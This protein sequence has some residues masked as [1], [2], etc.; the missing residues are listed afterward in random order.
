MGR[1]AKY[2]LAIDQGTT[3]TRSYLFDTQGRVAGSAY[4]EFTQYFPRPGWVEHDA[5]EIWKSAAATTRKALKA[6]GAKP[7]DIAAIGITNQRETTLL[8]DRKSGKPV[9]RAIVWQCRRT[10]ARC[11]QLKKQGKEKLFRARTGLVLDAYFSGTKLEWLLK[12]VKGARQKARQGRLAF[13]T[14]DSWLLWK[15]SGG[16]VHATDYSNA[17]RTLLFNI[18]TKKWDRELCK[19]L[20]VPASLLPEVRASAADFGVTG[21]KSFLGAGI[22]IAG[23]AGDQQA[24]LYGQ[25]CHAPGSLKN[26]YGTGCFLVLNLGKR[27]LLS[28]NKLL[29][30]LVCDE[31]GRPAYGLEGA[32]FIG[33]AAIQWVRDGLGLIRHAG[34]TQKI[35]ASIKDSGGVYLVPAFT[36]LG[37]PYWDPHARGAIVGLTRGSGRAQIVRAALES[38][39]YQSRD[40]VE[41]MLKDARL[42]LK[43]LRVDG[44]ACKN[45]LLMKFQAGMLGVAI[46][47]PRMVETTA[48]GAAFLA[49]LH[50][51][52]WKSPAQLRRL[53]RRDKIFRP[54]MD[55][56]RRRALWAGW[57]DAVARVRSR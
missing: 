53:R 32:V 54:G 37:A 2:V 55:P 43:E 30:T 11:D 13:G 57:Q 9:H 17:S 7:F 4:Q 52:F 12:N 47:R 21:A 39:A 15:L 36:G 1:G 48:L 22:P 33:G 42:N 3:G 46:N 23:I 44:G 16:A 20:G 14:I 6:A 50:T 26:T 29:T 19:I 40:V 25:G 41:A 18:K 27:F 28:K 34:E 49:G 5:E 35:A 31:W 51:G 56:A 10:A 24:A 38:L 8:W 45:D